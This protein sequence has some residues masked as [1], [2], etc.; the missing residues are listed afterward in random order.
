MSTTTVTTTQSRSNSSQQ[1]TGSSQ[2]P[3]QSVTQ[4]T[5]DPT[6]DPL[7]QAARVINDRLQKDEQWTGVGD[8]LGCEFS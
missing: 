8:R 2:Q 5:E 3:Q 6:F 1:A 7:T 4:A